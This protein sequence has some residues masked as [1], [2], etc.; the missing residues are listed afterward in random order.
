MELQKPLYQRRHALITGSSEPT[1]DEVVE[2]EK[3]SL[4]DDEDYTP[5]PKDT[6]NSTSGI[7][8]FWLTALRNHIGLSEIITDRDAEALKSLV[9]LQLSYLQDKPGFTLTFTFAPNDF[10]ENETLEKTYIYQEEVGYAGDF[11]YDKAIGTEI[12]WKD[13]QDLTKEYEVKK[14]RNKSTLPF[15]L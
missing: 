9:D 3:Q 13:D 6:P 15:L 2:G 11:V 8:Q 14:Q 5:L 1:T 4:K 7:P 12:K 10:F